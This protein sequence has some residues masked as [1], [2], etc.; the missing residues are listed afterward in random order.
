MLESFSTEVSPSFITD[1]TSRHI[2]IGK[3]CDLNVEDQKDFCVDYPPV[4][5]SDL[6][7]VGFNYHLKKF[8][9]R[10]P[11][12]SGVKNSY[13]MFLVDF[14][15]DLVEKPTSCEIKMPAWNP[16]QGYFSKAGI[17][18]DQNVVY[19]I[20]NEYPKIYVAFNLGDQQGWTDFSLLNQAAVELI[21]NK[22]VPYGYSFQIDDI[23][24][25]SKGEWVVSR[26]IV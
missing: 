12:P 16:Q 4:Y 24:L 18:D 26:S 10:Y 8:M 20:Q 19:V 15:A 7:F 14:D 2:M 13:C 3:F 23:R 5:S 9:V 21:K 1:E 22:Q 6:D 11:D 25:N 17:S